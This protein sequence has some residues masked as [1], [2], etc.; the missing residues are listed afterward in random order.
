MKYTKK[1]FELYLNRL[2]DE[3]GIPESGF[4]IGGKRRKMK[5]GTAM[6]LYDPIGFDYEF[7]HSFPEIVR[8][9]NKYQ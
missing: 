6:R 3:G 5:Y 7:R 4:I 9:T 8:E 1:E 2:G